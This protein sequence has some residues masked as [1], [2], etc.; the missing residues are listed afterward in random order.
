MTEPERPR[1]EERFENFLKAKKNLADAVTLYRQRPMSIVEQ[2]GLIQLFEIT[3][4][5]GWKVLGDYLIFSGTTDNVRTPAGAIRSAYASG[6]IEDGQRWMDAATL[7]HTVAHEYYPL[8]AASGLDA[9]SSEYLAMFDALE[10]TLAN[11]VGRS[12]FP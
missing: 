9:I 4:E 1:W 11:E 3:W 12:R 8:R 10:Q 5:V 7:R 2:A 6:V